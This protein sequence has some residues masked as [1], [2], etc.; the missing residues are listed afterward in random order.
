MTMNQSHPDIKDISRLIKVL[1]PIFV[2]FVS[3]GVV[4]YHLVEKWS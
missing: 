2:A 4:F 1:I 3:L